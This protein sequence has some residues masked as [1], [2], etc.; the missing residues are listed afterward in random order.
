MKL[1]I[2]SLKHFHSCLTAFIYLKVH[3]K[4][5][6]RVVRTLCIPTKQNGPLIPAETN[7]HKPRQSD[8]HTQNIHIL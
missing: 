7:I 3:V 8:S 1:E 2:H 5:Q 6:V 4:Q